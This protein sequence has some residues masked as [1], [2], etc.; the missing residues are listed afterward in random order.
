ML[1]S[2]ILFVGIAV[3]AACSLRA[4]DERAFV[5]GP[6]LNVLR[7]VPF[8]RLLPRHG[9]ERL[10]RHAVL[11]TVPAGA[12]VIRQGDPGDSFYVIVAGE[13]SV[14]AAGVQVATP[15]PG[16]YFGEIALLRN[17]SR[18]ATV[19]AVTELELVALERLDFLAAV[20][21][22]TASAEH[23]DDEINRRLAEHPGAG[24]Q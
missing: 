3:V 15:G 13:A 1:A 7:Q 20:T 5:P 16:D 23:L 2:G 9:L 11:L 18:T 12:E 21:G 6:E 8:L 24:E 19:S 4:V 14:T 10:S 22:S 17:V